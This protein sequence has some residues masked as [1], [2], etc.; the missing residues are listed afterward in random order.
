M[1]YKEYFS[2]IEAE[3]SKNTIEEETLN[4]IEMELNL[5]FGPEL[6]EYILTYGYLAFQSVEFYGINSIQGLDSDMVKQTI[7]LHKYFEK[8]NEYVA[9]GNLGEGKYA[10]VS[11]DDLVFEYDTERDLLIGTEKKLFEY[12]MNLFERRL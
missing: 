6:R 3:Y 8:T 4:S 5:K 9:L 12:I 7:Y 11:Q 10:L 2:K 1:E